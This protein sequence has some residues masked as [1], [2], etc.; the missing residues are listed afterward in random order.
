MGLMVVSDAFGSV[1][2]GAEKDSR[3]SRKGSITSRA[4]FLARGRTFE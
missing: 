3:R 4:N 2:N 1:W